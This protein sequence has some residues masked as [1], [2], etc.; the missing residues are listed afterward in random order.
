MLTKTSAFV[1]PQVTCA[2]KAKATLRYLA[3]GFGMSRELFSSY[4]VWVG[5]D[6]AFRFVV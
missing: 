1:D 3:W 5:E 4:S 6:I 2:L